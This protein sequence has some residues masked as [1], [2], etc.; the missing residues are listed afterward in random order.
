MARKTRSDA[1]TVRATERDTALLKWIAEQYATR[2]DQL[3]RLVE[4]DRGA[5]VTESNIKWLLGRWHKAGW[6]E[7]QKLLARKPQWVWLSRY[8]LNDFGL[9]FP[10]LK[11]SVGRLA[12]MYQ[13]NEVRQFIEQKRPETVWVSE[14]QANL[15]RKQSDKKHRVDGEVY[16]EGVRIAVEVELSQKSRGR[17]YSIMTELKKDYDTIWYF[18]HP[19]CEKAVAE[20]I[21]RIPYHQDTFIMYRLTSFDAVTL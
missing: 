10:Y 20:A 15:V 6:I 14:R 4:S 2:F 12:H 21:K 11:P 17:M 7:R 1:G 18:V 5:P 13:V 8:G 19:D 3:H 16:L 9:E